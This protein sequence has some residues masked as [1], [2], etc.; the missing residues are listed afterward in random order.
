MIK[1]IGFLFLVLQFTACAELTSIAGALGESG[2]LTNADIGNGL[3]E[4]LKIGISKGSDALSAKD[5]YFKSSYKILLPEEAQK[6]ANK[7]QNIPGFNQVENVILE[8]IN[9]AAEDAA[10]KAKP[11][12]VN[13]IKQ[14]TFTDALDILMGSNDAATDYLSRNT[15]RALYDEFKPIIVNSLNKF[16]AID[17]WADAI[18][19]Y[20]KIP[21]ITKMNPSLDDYVATQ[22]LNGLFSMVEKEEGVIRTNVSSRTTDL[23]KK[24]FA[25]QDNK[26]STGG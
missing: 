3:K 14:M 26:T 4:A 25:K 1:K 9:R 11:I 10:V 7:L 8:K 20:N 22:A 21:F 16:N 2:A 23:L 24:V 15:R 17:Y 6:V 19:T 12:F 5:G 13:A 18:N